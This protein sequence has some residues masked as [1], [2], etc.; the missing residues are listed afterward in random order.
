MIHPRPSDVSSF[1]WE[2]LEKDMDV[3]GQTLDQN[4]DNTVV[5]VHLILNTCTGFTTGSRGATQDLSSR[6]GRQQW[7]KFVCVSA[8]NPVL[9]DL[10][11]NLSEAQDRIGAD[12]GLAGSPLRILLYKDPHADP[13]LRLPDTPL[14]LLDS[15]TDA[16]SEALLP[17]GGGGT[18]TQPPPPAEP[19]HHQGTHHLQG[20]IPCVRQ[21]HHLPELA[22]LQSDLLRVFPLTSD[23]TDKTIAQMLQQI[24][25]G[26]QKKMLNERVKKFMKV[27]NCLRAE[28]ANCKHV[29]IYI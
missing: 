24:P 2:H 17:A 19:L 28:V 10:K 22:A 14:L 8:I 16:D 27:W 7:E 5:T 3:L 21:L 25:A 9:Q 6:Q 12:D 23:S 29:S 26:Y 13:P 11:K 20:H 18:G 4:M 15:S 1:L